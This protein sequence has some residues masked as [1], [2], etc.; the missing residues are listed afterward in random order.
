MELA[1]L[2]YESRYFIQALRFFASL[3]LRE[4]VAA[5]DRERERTIRVLTARGRGIASVHRGLFAPRDLWP[6]RG[7]PCES[8]RMIIRYN[9][10][11]EIVKVTQHVRALTGK[12]IHQ[13]RLRRRRVSSLIQQRRT[14]SRLFSPRP[15][16]YPSDRR[17]SSSIIS[18]S[19]R[20]RRCH[21]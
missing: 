1:R 11:D 9:Q 3:V 19:R 15:L 4:R 14:D 18:Y 12:I 5:R 13:T 17:A 10:A 16:Q 21:R 8:R 7:T 6:T 20:R 2:I